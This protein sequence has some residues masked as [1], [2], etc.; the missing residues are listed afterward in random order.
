MACGCQKRAVVQTTR[1][2]EVK[3]EH[4]PETIDPSV[5]VLDGEEL[6]RKRDD[7]SK[8]EL[9]SEPA[10][11]EALEID[12]ISCYEC[13]KKHI[14]RA[15]AFFEEYHTGYSVHIKNLMNSL[16]VAEE[17]V[18]RAFLLWQKTQAQ[19][20]MASGELLG[21]DLNEDTMSRDHIQLAND[22]RAARLRLNQ[23]PLYV[24]N[25]D[26]MLLRVQLLE[27]GH[28]VE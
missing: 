3:T 17:E 27:F 18:Q 9:K 13:V 19:L 14:G 8:E 11:K 12:I 15:Q 6:L 1:N 28:S 10:V 7:K 26:V 20:D 25:F 2:T 5:T 16:K 23:D 24:P 21:N 4:Q 22:I